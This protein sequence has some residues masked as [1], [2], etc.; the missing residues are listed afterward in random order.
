MSYDTRRRVLLLV[1]ALIVVTLVLASTA[2]STTTG[3]SDSDDAD[4][5]GGELTGGLYTE[6]MGAI[7]AE[8]SERL[9]QLPSPPEE[10]SRAD[11]AGEVSRALRAEAAAFDGIRV[12]ESRRDDHASFVENT[13]DQAEQWSALAEVLA[14]AGPDD[15]AIGETATAI[16]ELTLGRDELASEMSLATCQGRDLG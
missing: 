11:W 4:G 5:G 15:P 10:I 9:S 12:G 14:T 16:A 7:C 1:V 8:T 6:S 2:C 13:E 3:G